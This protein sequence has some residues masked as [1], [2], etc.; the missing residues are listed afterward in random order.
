MLR[1]AIWEQ[2]EDPKLQ[3]EMAGFSETDKAEHEG[4]RELPAPTMETKEASRW[5]CPS[6][7][8]WGPALTL[9][10][11]PACIQGCPRHR[12]CQGVAMVTGVGPR[13]APISALPQSNETKGFPSLG[14]ARPQPLHTQLPQVV[15]SFPPSSST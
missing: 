10:Q 15:F 9:I 14:R 3:I 5:G 8:P 1:S 2:E 7:G 13:E 11:L 6:E 4:P 12:C